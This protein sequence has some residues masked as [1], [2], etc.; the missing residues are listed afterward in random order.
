MS[1][2]FNFTFFVVFTFRFILPSDLSILIIRDLIKY[3]FL[4]Q[5]LNV[6]SAH[7]SIPKRKSVY[8]KRLKIFLSYSN[9]QFRQMSLQVLRTPFLSIFVL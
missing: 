9:Q 2:D 3:L 4:F 8:T 1:L 5:M 7:L 6:G